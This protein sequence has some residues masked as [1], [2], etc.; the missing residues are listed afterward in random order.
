[1]VERAY[2]IFDTAIGR[3][4]IAWS[5]AGVLGVQLPEAREIET[6]KRFFLLYPDARETRPSANAEAAIEGIVDM[7]RGKVSD[8]S[9]IVLDM[10]GVHAFDQRVYQ[11][12]RQ[13]LRSETLTYDEVAARLGTPSA[14]RSVAQAIARNPFVVIVPCHRVLEAGGYTDRMSL[15]AGLISK[16][17]LLSIEGAGSLSSKSLLDILLPVSQPRLPG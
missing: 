11:A 9:D 7:L 17:R 15:H 6:R 5:H 3:C 10:S 14:V 4:G 12:V 8:L 16:R 1:M 2:A 13:I